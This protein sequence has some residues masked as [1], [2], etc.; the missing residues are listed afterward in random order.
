LVSNSNDQY[1]LSLHYA[2]PIY[3]IA[4]VGEHLF[5]RTTG[6]SRGA[7]EIVELLPALRQQGYRQSMLIRVDA[8][9]HVRQPR[10]QAAAMWA[11]LRRH[12]VQ[13]CV[14]CHCR[15]T[16]ADEWTAP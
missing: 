13:S 3:V 5:H 11:P 14:A 6:K 4:E 2:L 8:G 1:T 9:S 16:R 10:D 7:N 15:G 12:G